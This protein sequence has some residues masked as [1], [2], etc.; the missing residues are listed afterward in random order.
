MNEDVRKLNIGCGRKKIDGYTNIDG[1]SWNGNTDII[2]D[3]TKTP[4]PFKDN[5]IEEIVCMEV[6]EHISFNDTLRVLNEFYRI[7]DIGGTLH[8]QVPDCGRM[9]EYYVNGEVCEC[10]PHKDTGDG[11][12]ANPNCTNCQGKAKVNPMRW[13]LAFTGASK[14]K[15]DYHLNIFT[16]ECL[17]LLLNIAQF[18]GLEWKDNINKLIV[19][20]IK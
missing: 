8:L 15:F 17:E 18:N 20:C 12:K 14:H 3:I 19:K 11:F 9:M 13:L 7:L 2:W 1:L 10:V 5:Q 4:Y 6:L 16:R